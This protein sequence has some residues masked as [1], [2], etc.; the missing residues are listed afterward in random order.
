MTLSEK[1]KTLFALSLA[2]LL[3]TPGSAA[4]YQEGER[5]QASALLQITLPGREPFYLLVTASDSVRRFAV[6][7]VPSSRI[8]A[9]KVAPRK[10]ANLIRI[11]VSTLSGKLGQITSCDQL[12]TLSERPV[13]FYNARGGD[14]IRVSELIG[15]G[16]RP[17]EI[18][19]IKVTSGD[20]LIC[21]PGRCCC[22]A[23][24]CR[25]NT[26]ACVECGPCA[27]CCLS[28]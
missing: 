26:G 7:P 28:G 23:L 10:E 18:P 15:F 9:V 12:R 14:I 20:D 11:E 25:A 21:P 6:I 24:S 19:E 2:A 17:F 16:V 3:V 1:R 22:G 13:A 4:V 27:L 5:K 8:S